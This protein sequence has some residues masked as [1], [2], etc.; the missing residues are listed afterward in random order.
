MANLFGT[1]GVRG[2]ANHFP[3]DAETALK[4]G[5][6]AG[7]H[8]RRGSHRHK[9]VI[10]KDTRLSGYLI[11]PALT[12]GFISMGMDVVLLGPL[13]T[14]AVSTITRSMRADL[15]VMISAS[16]NPY[17]DNGIKF[18]LPN[19]LKLSD[20]VEEEL[21]RLV[22][23]DLSDKK[24]ADE[25]LGRAVRLDDAVGRYIEYV[26]Q[27]FPK[28]LTL[29]GLKVVIDCAHG[30]AYKI[31][32]TI[33]WELG[34]EIIPIG[35]QPNGFNINQQC[36]S[37]YAKTLQQRVVEEGADIGIALDGDAD[38]MI[39][40]D[41]KG[42]V[43]D[44]DQIIG[45]IA[46]YWHARGMLR[47]QGVVNTVMANLGLEQY[48]A[49]QELQ[50]VRTQVGDRYVAEAM[51][52]GG[53]NLGG[54]PSGHIIFNDYTTTG[55]GLIAGLQALAVMVEQQRPASEA[56]RVFTPFPQLLQNV[57]VKQ[58]PDAVLEKVAE[59]IRAAEAALGDKGRVLI[60]KSGTEPLIRVMT[61]GEDEAAI[62]EANNALVAAIEQ[63]AA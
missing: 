1:D 26:K 39:A 10:G 40:V 58:R 34:A 47:G 36:G 27:S 32:P 50:L 8:F 24:P 41:E 2:L 35:T 29:D 61:E 62:T 4:L 5:M 16:H 12:A 38:R 20:T 18:F 56:L 44:G 28:R 55:D 13:P 49:A 21:C 43:I 53:F 25:A 19:G 54:E 7:Y 3:M 17:H 42:E 48:L 63:A 22:E 46:S 15:G 51:R 31:A 9:V 6:A 30:A 60:R 23:S 59:D 37:T 52:E 57:R 45:A 14:P 11:E 33:L